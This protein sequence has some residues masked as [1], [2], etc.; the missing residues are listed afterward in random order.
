MENQGDS[1]R[2]RRGLGNKLLIFGVIIG[3]CLIIAAGIG[4]Y[5]FYFIRTKG[6]TLWVT[7]SVK[8][9]VVSDL[10]KWTGG[11]SRNIP[12]EDLTVGYAKMKE[13]E[14][15]T[16]EFFKSYGF[17]EK[18][19]LISPVFM[20]S[21]FQYDPNVPKEYILRQNVEIQSGDIAKITDM[22]KNAQILIEKGVIFSTFSLEYYYTKLPE[23]R[24]ALLKDAA[25]DAKMRAQKIAESTGLSVG[26]IKSADAGI[27]QVL[28]VNSNAVSDW[29]TYDTSTVEKEVMVTV[30]AQFNLK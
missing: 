26:S 9:K 18:D 14:K 6:D 10:A 4:S 3:L 1:S 19:I 16:I 30:T 29:G 8:Q 28:Q 11:Y 23:L 5:T 22:T 13:D 15:I 7:G 20:E 17:T 25:Q 21:P 27:V 24:I 2:D 12:V